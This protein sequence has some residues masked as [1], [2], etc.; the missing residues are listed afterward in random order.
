[1]LI[2]LIEFTNL[3]VSSCYFLQED[4][5]SYSCQKVF[6]GFTTLCVYE[7]ALVNSKLKSAPVDES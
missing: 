2:I 7:R 1:M 6:T 5:T 3:H 4:H